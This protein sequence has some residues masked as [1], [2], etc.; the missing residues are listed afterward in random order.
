MSHNTIY[1]TVAMLPEG[2]VWWEEKPRPPKECTTDRQAMTP[3]IA[4][5]NG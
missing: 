5:A 2:D 1:T 3:E 4:D